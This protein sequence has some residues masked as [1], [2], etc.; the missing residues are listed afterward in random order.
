NR[1][2]EE[3]LPKLMKQ[4]CR[5]VDV[6]AVSVAVNIKRVTDDMGGPRRKPAELLLVISLSVFEIGIF[7]AEL[8]TGRRIRGMDGFVERNPKRLLALSDTVPNG[9]LILRSFGR[10]PHCFRM[11]RMAGTAEVPVVFAAPSLPTAALYTKSR[12]R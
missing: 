12:N 5:C 11:D 10:Q 8:I 9:G 3:F 1:D 2:I 7:D 4:L 6:D